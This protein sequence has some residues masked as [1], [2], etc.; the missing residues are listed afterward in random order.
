[1]PKKPDDEMEISAPKG[2][3]VST[4]KLR[5]MD[6]ERAS[7]QEQEIQVFIEKLKPV[8]PRASDNEV[9]AVACTVY[10]LDPPGKEHK[11]MDAYSE[12]FIQQLR[13]RDF[14]S[15]EADVMVKALLRKSKMHLPGDDQLKQIINY[16]HPDDMRAFEEARIN[17]QGASGPEAFPVEGSVIFKDDKAKL[18]ADRRN[19][20][21]LSPFRQE[22]IERAN[23]FSEQEA[24]EVVRKA[25]PRK[26]G[27][28]ERKFRLQ[29]APDEDLYTA[30]H[31]KIA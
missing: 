15:T 16:H 28:E 4:R 23:R 3:G 14:K 20:E 9:I 13:K 22:Q 6:E 12:Q 18:G 27:A 29:E 1:M 7:I 21:T 26:A 5:A 19:W 10:E 31:F 11:S 17:M 24:G 25:K 30:P 8:F 2:P